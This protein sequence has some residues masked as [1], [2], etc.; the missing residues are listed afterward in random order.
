[1]SMKVMARRSFL[2]QVAAIV[3]AVGLG[4][5]TAG[6]TA[7]AASAGCVE[8]VADLMGPKLDSFIAVDPD[9]C[10]DP[11]MLTMRFDAAGFQA[12]LGAIVRQFG[13]DEVMFAIEATAPAAFNILGD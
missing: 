7:R 11:T 4:V 12:A 6:S 10:G 13:A 5:A 2:T 8:A 1:M 9:I 3:G